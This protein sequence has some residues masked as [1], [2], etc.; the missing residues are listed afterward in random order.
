MASVSR[1][2]AV[3][4]RHPW[5]WGLA[6][7]VFVVIVILRRSELEQLLRVAVQGI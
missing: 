2:G 3:P 6:A 1:S 7:L 4:V 5:V